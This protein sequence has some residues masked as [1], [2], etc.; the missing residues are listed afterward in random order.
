MSTAEEDPQAT[1]AGKAIGT[2]VAVFFT[3]ATLV[4]AFVTLPV[5]IPRTVAAVGLTF[6]VY[7]VLLLLA[8]LAWLLSG[9]RNRATDNTA[10]IALV[11]LVTA[12]GLSYLARLELSAIIFE[13][14][15]LVVLAIAVFVA[16]R[17]FRTIGARYVQ[18]LSATLWFSLALTLFA[19]LTDLDLGQRVLA[20]SLEYGDASAA[21]RLITDATYPSVAVL[22]TCIC[23]Y[24]MGRL[25]TAMWGALVLPAFLIVLLSFSRNP[26]ISL[27]FGVAVAIWHSPSV[28]TA[29]RAIRLIVLTG[30]AV[31]VAWL[32]ALLD[33][34]GPIA[35]WLSAQTAGF[36]DRVLGGLSA[37]ALATDSS[38]LYRTDQENPYLE[39]AFWQ[40]PLIGHGFGFEYKPAFT[41]RYYASEEIAIQAS[42]YAHQFYLWLAVK[43]GLVGLAMFLFLALRPALR[44]LRRNTPHLTTA[45]ASALLG[46]MAQSF[47]APM[48]VGSPTSLL[49]GALL[50]FVVAG[51]AK[52]PTTARTTS[53]R[54]FG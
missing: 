9:K 10:F 11:L 24:L 50:G 35:H 53:R 39:T 29:A 41:G 14:R 5:W 18:V 36:T 42:R 27:A 46:M 17:A 1:T 16:G 38:T 28:A 32:F 19:S 33:S 37:Q 20:A 45:F 34:G 31:A 12:F 13:T 3:M 7:E 52:T 22:T 49:F 47:F 30:L 26:L 23:L 21:V 54:K 51:V 4:A 15:R 48:P 40:S 2:P 6:Q 44:A 43:T 8:A 25:P